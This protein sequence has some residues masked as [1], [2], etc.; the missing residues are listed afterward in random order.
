M[1]VASVWEA[2]Q[3]EL[4]GPGLNNAVLSVDN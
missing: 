2:V 1:P 4:R 3:Q